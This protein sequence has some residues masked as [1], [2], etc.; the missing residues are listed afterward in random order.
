[1]SQFFCRPCR[2]RGPCQSNSKDRHP[3]LI[4]CGKRTGCEKIQGRAG[5]WSPRLRRS[6][7][8]G[9]RCLL[10]LPHPYI[11][12]KYNWPA[13]PS[14]RGRRGR[15]RF[16]WD[17]PSSMSGEPRDTVTECRGCRRI[18]Q[19]S[20]SWTAPRA[21]RHAWWS[22][23]YLSSSVPDNSTRHREVWPG[24]ASAACPRNAQRC[25]ALPRNTRTSTREGQSAGQ[26]AGHVSNGKKIVLGF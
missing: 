2:L 17:V 22:L 4:R 1:M 19:S 11:T 7:L 9:G 25:P 26:S 24:A 21:A 14:P 10:S 3:F 5:S 6:S 13:C 12:R 8:Q 18:G 23:S 16:Q 15:P 20:L